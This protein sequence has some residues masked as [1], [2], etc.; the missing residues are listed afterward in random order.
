MHAKMSMNIIIL[1]V[2][3]K[4]SL[5]TY[6]TSYCVV[7]WWCTNLD[8]DLLICPY[9]V[10]T[11]WKQLNTVATLCHD[12]L[13]HTQVTLKLLIS[14]HNPRGIS[15]LSYIPHLFG[16][17]FCTSVVQWYHIWYHIIPYKTSI[18]YPKCWGHTYM[19][20]RCSCTM[21]FFPSSA[22][23]CAYFVHSTQW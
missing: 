17:H 15:V 3:I 1:A 20:S 7:Y 5:G 4:W 19:Q 14:C 16:M 23:M 12:D 18:M 9:I 11:S 13:I 2:L 8:I 21:A 6:M 22:P 10:C